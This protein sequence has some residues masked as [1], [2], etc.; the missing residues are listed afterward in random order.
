M[1]TINT[2][3]LKKIIVHRVIHID[4]KHKIP[5]MFVQEKFSKTMKCWWTNIYFVY[6]NREN[7]ATSYYQWLY[8]GKKKT[9]FEFL[10]FI[11][12]HTKRGLDRFFFYCAHT[13]RISLSAAIAMVWCTEKIICSGGRS[14][15]VYLCSS[16]DFIAKSIYGLF[17]QCH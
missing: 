1:I 5:F 9:R 4:F 8:F 16:G 15:V 7:H 12:N 3:V 10:T 13:V 2:L 17:F 14:F 11:V 6:L